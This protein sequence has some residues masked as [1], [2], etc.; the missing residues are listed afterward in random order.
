MEKAALSSRSRV[1]G[2]LLLPVFQ[3]AS[4]TED[5]PSPWRR[6]NDKI[7]GEMLKR[8]ENSRDESWHLS[9]RKARNGGPELGV[10]PHFLPCSPRT[11]PC[12]RIDPRSAPD[13]R[14]YILS[15]GRELGR[16]ESGR[17]LSLLL[18]EGPLSPLP[19]LDCPAL[20]VCAELLTLFSV[21]YLLSR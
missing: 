8:K 4:S 14:R 1:F 7:R 11:G 18:R 19:R 17:T 15:S 13:P 16:L 6:R 20:L 12:L 10:P 21:V 2:I 5:R 9:Q 3:A